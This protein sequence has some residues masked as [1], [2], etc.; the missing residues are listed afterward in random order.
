[1]C[2][3]DLPR[4]P[5]PREATPFSRLDATVPVIDSAQLAACV[6]TSG[7]TGA[8][9]PYRKSWGRLIACVREEANRLG[10][11]GSPACAIVATF[12]P[13]HMYGFESSVLLALLCGHAVCSERLF[14]PAN[15]TGVLAAVP[16]PRIL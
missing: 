13:Q 15:I 8:P 9:V 4:V 10:L 6:F 2:G 12:P 7:S 11:S 14:Y 1:A 16:P 5:F 3:I